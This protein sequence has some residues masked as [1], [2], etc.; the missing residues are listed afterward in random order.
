MRPMGTYTESTTV[1][2]FLRYD[3]C[4][5]RDSGPFTP[6]LN[7]VVGTTVQVAADGCR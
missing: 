6:Y 3:R 5:D 4:R 1:P 7:N 2:F